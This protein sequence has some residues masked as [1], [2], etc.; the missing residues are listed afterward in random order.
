VSLQPLIPALVLA[1]LASVAAMLAGALWHETWLAVVAAALYAGIITGAALHINTPLWN[2]IAPAEAALDNV[3]AARR[4]ARLAALVYGWAAAALL[5]FHALA[6]LDWYH[7]WQYGL[8][9]ALIAAGL[10]LLVRR[11]GEP[12]HFRAPPL[13]LT[14]LHAAIVGGGLAFLIG[15][16]KVWS[17]RADWAANVVFLWGGLSLIVLCLVAGYTQRRLEAQAQGRGE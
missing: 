17:T 7:Y 6:G 5:S 4:N 15:S 8:G 11:M 14:A 10:I 2:G 1:L 12:A 3:H 16:G 13:A 9:A